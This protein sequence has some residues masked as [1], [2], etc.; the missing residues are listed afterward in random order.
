[1]QGQQKQKQT[2]LYQTKNFF[3]VKETINRKKTQP[4]KWEKVFANGMSD[5]GLISKIYGELKQFIKTKS[6]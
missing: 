5:K 2:G 1:M 4:T 6:N 3:R